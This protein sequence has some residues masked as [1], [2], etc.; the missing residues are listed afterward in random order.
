MKYPRTFF[1]C[2]H[3]GNLVGMVDNAGVKIIC[4]GEPM[5]LVEAN[6]VDAAVEKHIPAVTRNDNVLDVVV[7]EVAHPMTEDHH[8]AWV[9]AAQEHLTVRV[10][11]D[12]GADPKAQLL[13]GDGPVTVY[14]Y[15]NLHGLWG[16]DVE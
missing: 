5:R 15:C 6:T 16:V 4:C 9:M 13:V 8:I 11:L 7:G 1:K 10:A 12:V 14:A 2:D 3:C